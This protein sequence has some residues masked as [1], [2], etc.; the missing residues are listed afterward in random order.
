[1]NRRDRRAQSAQNAAG[2]RAD[3]LMRTATDHHRAGR[4]LPART[5]YRKLVAAVPGNADVHGLLAACLMDMGD[6]QDAGT[7]FREAARLAPNDP[8]HQKNLAL[9]LNAAGDKVAAL[10]PLRRAVALA[11]ND[12]SLRATLGTL[13]ADVGRLDDAAAELKAVLD[14]YP[15]HMAAARALALVRRETGD[16]TGAEAMMLRLLEKPSPPPGLFTD[17]AALL[18]D[19]GRDGEALTLLGRCLSAYPQHREALFHRAMIRL[20]HGEFAPGWA[21]YARGTIPTDP[22]PDFS[23]EPVPPDLAGRRIRVDRDQG[24]G[25]EIFFL[26]F[27]AE[28]KRRG[29]YVTYRGDRRLTGMI[30]RT[31]VVDRAIAIREDAGACDLAYCAAHLPHLLDANEPPPSI[32]LPSDAARVADMKKRLDA[33]GDAPK[34]GITWR[35][36]TQARDRLS[37]IAPQDGIAEALKGLPVTLVALQRNPHDGEMRRFAELSGV[38]LH[39]FTGLNDDLDG[40]HALLGLLDDYVCVSNTNVHLRAAHGLPSRI[41]VPFPAEFRWMQTDGA[42]PW[43]PDC[44]VYRETYKDGWKPAIGALSADLAA[45]WGTPS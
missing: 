16:E 21:D 33:L 17:L 4:L 18:R 39:D 3:A 25:D 45:A 7:H 29:A 5:A 26:R 36:G 37:K 12:A 44:P 1:M 28:L 40:M 20:R 10:E 22:A 38:E 31:D 9:W 27:V 24:L 43:F 32:R 35:A 23:A 14:R 34:I 15:D 2:A 8:S 19:T 11:P 30:G 41:L 13:L 6:P 42:S